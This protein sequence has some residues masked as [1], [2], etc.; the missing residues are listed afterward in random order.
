MRYCDSCRRRSAK[1]TLTHNGR[2]IHV[3]RPCAK[4]IKMQR[5][6]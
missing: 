1:E 4:L 5:N 2:T 6:T 3:C